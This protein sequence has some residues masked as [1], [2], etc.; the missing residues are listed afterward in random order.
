[1]RFS[2]TLL[3]ALT[4][5]P[6]LS[7]PASAK[8]LKITDVTASSTYPEEKGRT[9]EPKN[10]KDQKLSTSWFEGVDG[11]GL[12]SWI[13]LTLE[14]TQSVSAVRI[15]NGDWI[16]ADL[17]K[18]ENRMQD[19]EIETSDG[20][21]YPFKLKDEMAAETLTFPSAVTTSSIRIRYKTIFRG[22]TFNDT[23]IS[24]IQVLDNTPSKTV[25]VS[26]YT[27]SSTYPADADGDYGP[28]NLGDGMIDSLWCENAKTD[29][30]GE[31]VQFTFGSSHTLQGMSIR[32]GNTSSLPLFMS[33]SHATG[34]TLTFSDGTTQQIPLKSSINDQLVPL[35][36]KSTSSV[37]VTVTGVSKGQDTSNTDLCFSEISFTE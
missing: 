19:I 28:D 37:K 8:P 16:T 2:T 20:T 29:G 15:W 18:R 17:W 35:G 11:G 21:K 4:L 34:V 22:S 3:R 10:V 23:G 32:N 13:E 14:G 12:G 1:M 30:T 24:E 5:L 27:A 9:Y 36:G 26:G 6:I 7:L 25:P 33:G 31:W